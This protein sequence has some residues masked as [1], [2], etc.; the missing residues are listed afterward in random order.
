MYK[1]RVVLLFMILFSFLFTGL[2]AKQLYDEEILDELYEIVLEG[3]DR[4]YFDLKG[5][6][7]YFDEKLENI[8][9]S[10]EL[11]YD[12]RGGR[13]NIYYPKKNL[14]GFLDNDHLIVVGT[15]NPFRIIDIDAGGIILNGNLTAD[16]MKINAGGIEMH[17]E[18]YVDV[19]KINGAGIDIRGYYDSGYIRINGAGINLHMDVENLE[20]IYINGAGIDADLFYVDTWTC[21]RE[22]TVN[23][24]AGDVNIMLRKDNIEQD[25]DINLNKKGIID[26][27]VSYY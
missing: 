4:V 8:Y 1:S 12:R 16:E 26:V 6:R 9:I 24:V 21:T 25:G 17:G 13:L 15:K 19:I 5:T 2:T 27:D 7:I 10:D 3:E 14:F 22:V 20:E 11:E 23:G 18:Y